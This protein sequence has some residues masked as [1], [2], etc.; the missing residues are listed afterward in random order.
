MLSKTLKASL[1]LAVSFLSACDTPEKITSVQHKYEVI[2]IDPP[3]RFYID[4]KNVET[5]EIF[6]SIYISKRCSYWQN[7]K[8]NSVWTFDELTY[9]YKDPSKNY[10][11][12]SV[13][14]NFCQKLGDLE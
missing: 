11:K 2:G 12:V 13:D 9:H 3:K 4:L 1:I 14:R 10:R 5:G 7:L 8:M 6:R